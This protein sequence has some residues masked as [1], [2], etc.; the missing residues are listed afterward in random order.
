MVKKRTTKEHV[1][2]TFQED[3]ATANIAWEEAEHNAM[4]RPVC[5]KMPTG[6]GGTK[7]KMSTLAPLS[8]PSFLVS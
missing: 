6:T 2:Q 7:T 5:V 4:D 8:S 1:A 3:L